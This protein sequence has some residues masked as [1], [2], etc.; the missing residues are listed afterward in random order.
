MFGRNEKIPSFKFTV[1]QYMV[2]A[3]FLLLAFGLWRL[4]ISSNDEY[5][6]R[7]E[8][9]PIRRLPI[10]APRGKIYDREGQLLVHNYPSSSPLLLRDQGRDLNPC[11]HTTAS[12][13][14]I[15]SA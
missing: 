10:L 13:L 9:N 15:R 6:V 1:V 8:Q 3:V 2:L 12:A 4:Q 5:S 11:V 7:P 14:H